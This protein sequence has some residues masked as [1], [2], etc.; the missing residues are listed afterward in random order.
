MFNSYRENTLVLNQEICIGCSMCAMVCPHAVFSMNDHKAL[1]VN[2]EA[3]MECGAC[4][5]NC[6]VGAISVHS[7]VG[8]ASAM[9]R[10]A[11]T[12]KKVSCDCA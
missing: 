9:I 12:G 6:P 1:I 3:C 5:L 8:C 11:L 2:Y 7:G 10:S 4:R